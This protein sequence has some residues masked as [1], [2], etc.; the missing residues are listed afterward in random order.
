MKP[1]AGAMNVDN[2]R[3]HPNFCKILACI[4]RRPTR[5]RCAPAAFEGYGTFLVSSRYN[6]LQEQHSFF[7][8][9]PKGNHNIKISLD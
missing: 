1:V 7:L 3:A 6:V 4:V 5:Q 2:G 9:L 8:Y